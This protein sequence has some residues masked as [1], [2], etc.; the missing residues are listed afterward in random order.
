ML[1]FAVTGSFCNFEKGLKTLDGLSKKYDEILP[2]L[3]YNAY[4]TDT[5]GRRRTLFRA[6]KSCAVTRWCI[7]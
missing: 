7:R 6:S 2:I 4:S 5:S 3:S 1:G